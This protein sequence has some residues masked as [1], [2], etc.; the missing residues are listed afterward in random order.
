M[1]EPIV[2]EI[3]IDAAPATVFEFFTD[4]SKLT[5]WLASEAT[6]DPRPSG[7]CHQV[8]PAA[9]VDDA[10]GGPYHMRGEFLEVSPPERV[11][12]TWGFAEPDVGVPPGSSVV[13][14]TLTPEGGGTRLRLVH[15]DLPPAAID[16]HAGGWTTMLDRLAAA[17]TSTPTPPREER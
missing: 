12:F 16:D 1:A 4:A 3:H 17:V 13:D 8:H 14:V 6:L 15:R 11:V 2:R 10:P 9:D 5:R 7:I